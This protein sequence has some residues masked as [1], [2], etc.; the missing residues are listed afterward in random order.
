M[1]VSLCLCQSQCF[2]VALYLNI[3]AFNGG[4]YHHRIGSQ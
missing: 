1:A 3:N 2:D 4:A